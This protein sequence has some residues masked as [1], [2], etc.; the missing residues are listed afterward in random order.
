MSRSLPAWKGSFGRTDPIEAGLGSRWRPSL[1]WHPELVGKRCVSNGAP[2]RPPS[3]ERRVRR[4]LLY[5]PP[6][7][8]HRAYMSAPA[9][10]GCG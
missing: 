2:H 9:A 3:T 8:A 5:R 4:R 10:A 7:T 6:P 1:G